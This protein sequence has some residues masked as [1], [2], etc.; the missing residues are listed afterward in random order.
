MRPGDMVLRCYAERKGD[1]WQ[2]FCLDLN[3]A[4][5]GDTF[6]DVKSRLDEMIWSFVYDATVGEDAQ[7][8][9]QLLPRRAP[10]SYWLTYYWYSAIQRA[11]IAK[12]GVHC[13]FTTIMP[14]HPNPA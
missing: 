9:D 11:R 14:M 8:A 1:Q 2:A 5:H 7:Y 3:L 4:A 13:L 12:N 10:L 6:Q